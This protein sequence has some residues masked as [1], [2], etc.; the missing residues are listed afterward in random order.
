VTIGGFVEPETG[1][2]P[3]EDNRCREAA[4]QDAKSEDKFQAADNSQEG[5]Q[6]AT[7]SNAN[8]AVKLKF[9]TRIASGLSWF[10]WLAGLSMVNALL[11]CFKADLSMIFGLSITDLLYGLTVHF[12]G[13]RDLGLPGYGVVLG[14]TAVLSMIFFILGRVAGSGRLWPLYVA[15]VFYLLDGGVSFLCQ[16]WLALACHAWIMFR[17]VD[18]ITAHYGLAKYLKAELKV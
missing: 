7:V 16:S 8:D 17:F 2:G 5:V 3:R 12:Q 15:C 1:Q 18:A 6:P 10:N 4:A 9:I 14:G 13:G 11:L